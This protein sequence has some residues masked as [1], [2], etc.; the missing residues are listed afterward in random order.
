MRDTALDASGSVF[1]AAEF[2][3]R[4]RR[5]REQM[6]AERLDAL[7]AYSNAAVTG[8]VQ[9]LSGYFSRQMGSQSRAD[10]SYYTYGGG[11]LLLPLDGEPTLVTDQLWDVERAQSTSVIS[12]TI[13]AEDFASELG[14]RI[15][16]AGYER[17][18]ID[19]WPIFPAPS[20]L[21]LREL[22][23]AAEFVP[24]RLIDEVRRTK[25]LAEIALIRKAEDA[26]VGAVEK[27]TDLV[28]V[29][30]G[31]F[32]LVRAAEDAL[33]EFGDIE[34]PGP[35]IVF[36][37]PRT[38]SSSGAPTRDDSYE[39][40][41]GDWAMF[42]LTPAYEGYA[43]DVCRMRVAGKPSDLDPELARLYD[44]TLKINEGVIE[45]I[46]PG[47]IPADLDALA[48]SIADEAGFAENKLGLTGHGLGLDMHEAPDYY[49][50]RCPLEPGMVF[51]VEPCLV[52]PDVAGVRI[53]DVVLVTENGCEVLSEA[54]P[55][56]LRGSED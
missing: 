49:Y 1:D 47:A 7:I 44:A 14:P 32:E 16:T 26:A 28:A 27:A 42:D 21:S 20:Y 19:T 22:A 46:R 6:E 41:R 53:E 12:E 2:A 29:G 10:G 13:A 25:S 33:R 24:T 17:V 48:L 31:D 45:A 55:K 36:A 43:G 38:A 9:Y 54:S 39:M 50:D 15:A 23:R 3:E 40:Q 37:G 30:I 4:H 18:G 35:S 52:I 51:T 56:Q 34:T 5:V 8:C 11:A